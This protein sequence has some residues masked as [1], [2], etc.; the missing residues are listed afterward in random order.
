ME[1]APRQLATS[2]DSVR[3]ATVAANRRIG[4]TLVA[5]VVSINVAA[6]IWDLFPIGGFDQV[7]HAYTLFA[8]AFL[9]VGYLHGAGWRRALTMWPQTT[10]PEQRAPVGASPAV[11]SYN[12]PAN[13]Q[14]PAKHPSLNG[15]EGDAQRPRVPFVTGVRLVLLTCPGCSTTGSSRRPAV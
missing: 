5:T 10:Q 1:V 4:W 15:A 6:Y 2:A 7:V 14:Y 8:C 12:I 13:T 9:G 3:P 11:P